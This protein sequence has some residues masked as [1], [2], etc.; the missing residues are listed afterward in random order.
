MKQSQAT[1]AN[2]AESQHLAIGA[3]SVVAVDRNG[4]AFN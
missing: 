1:G 4:L 3:N 2:S